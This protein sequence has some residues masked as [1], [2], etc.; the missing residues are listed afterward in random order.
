MTRAKR[1]DGIS[2]LYPEIRVALKSVVSMSNLAINARN[3]NDHLI[4]IKEI[5]ST[6]ASLL[7]TIDNARGIVESELDPVTLQNTQF[8]LDNVLEDLSNQMAESLHEKGI[9]LVYQVAAEQ[10]PRWGDGGSDE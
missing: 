10:L 1:S 9:A 7:K 6:A 8:S 2:G 3:T 4:Y 5:R